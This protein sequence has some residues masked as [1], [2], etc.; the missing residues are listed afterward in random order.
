MAAADEE[1][2]QEQP[3]V[4]TAAAAAEMTYEEGY[5]SD[6]LEGSG[7]EAGFNEF[8]YDRQNGSLTEHTHTF[9]HAEPDLRGLRIGYPHQ[10]LHQ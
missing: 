2:F 1:T 10:N 6:N 7:A 3:V 5:G 9:Q 4:V 8:E